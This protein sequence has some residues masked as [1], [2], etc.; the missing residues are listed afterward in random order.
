MPKKEIYKLSKS[1]LE[2]IFKGLILGDG[3]KQN[4][5]C[6]EFRGQEPEIIEMLQ[7]ICCLLGYR[8]TL[9]K[10]DRGYFRLYI[11]KRNYYQINKNNL[12][13]NLKLVNYNGIVW[14][15]QTKNLTFLAK[16]NNSIF[17]TGNSFARNLIYNKGVDI[18]T[19][20]KLLG[21]SSLATTMIYIN[22]DEKT[23]RNNYK[24][25]VG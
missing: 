22:P 3:C 18:N 12:K 15:P 7:T 6:I 14:C 10:D 17:L 19:V 9:S 23:I 1:E 16:R 25:L 13:T 20:S 4:Y 5:N 8:S 21:H 11:C 2:Y 24:K